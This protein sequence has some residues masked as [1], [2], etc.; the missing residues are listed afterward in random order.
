[1]SIERASYAQ[2]GEQHDRIEQPEA[3]IGALWRWI[4]VAGVGLALVAVLLVGRQGIAPSA[5]VT[6]PVQAV[7]SAP[8]LSAARPASSVPGYIE[9]LAPRPAAAP[10]SASPDMSVIGTGSVYDERFAAPRSSAE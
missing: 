4:A 10:L 1:M 8:S 3:G 9:Y 5:A 2:P 6:L 7:P